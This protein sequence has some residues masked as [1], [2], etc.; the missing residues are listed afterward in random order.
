MSDRSS[1]RNT[2]DGES[3]SGE[4]GVV[5]GADLQRLATILP[6][7]PATTRDPFWQDETRSLFL[8][9]ALYLLD[10]PEFPTTFRTPR[11]AVQSAIDSRC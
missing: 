4:R 8:G 10:T 2:L 11:A 5:G 7:A 9:L 6:P 3:G 1:T